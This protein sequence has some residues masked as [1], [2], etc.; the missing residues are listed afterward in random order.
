MRAEVELPELGD[1][2]VLIEVAFAG[3]NRHDCN[4]RRRG[5]SPLHSDTPG[6]EV[7]GIISGLGRRV[8]QFRIGDPV[9]ALVDGGG[10]ATHTTASAALVFPVL[11]ALDLKSASA[12]PE[13]LFTIWHNFVG[14]SAIGQG[15]SVLIHGGT[16]GVGS[17]A[18]QL[19]SRLGHTVFATCSSTEKMEHAS[20]L[21]A[22]AAFNYTN[23][24]FASEVLSAT[25]GQGVDV[26]L[27][28]AA[29]AHSSANLRALAWRG[30]IVHL[31]P[32][33]D[34]I[35]KAPLRTILEKEAK[36]TGSLLRPLSLSI[37]SQVADAL[38]KYVL[39][40]VYQGDVLPW[41]NEVYPLSMAAQAHRELESGSS[42]GKIVLEC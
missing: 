27:D 2:E 41:V 15:E 10:Y 36:I 3:V 8:H 19:L 4:Q 12:L 29:G 11:G 21:G 13:A 37:K 33:D 9:C 31:S 32:G 25:R 26:I 35:F 16:S 39:P 23:Q 14:V 40:L 7:S 24:D 38:R 6:L 1:E 30:R 18:I 28:V 5:P 20:R 17:L 42:M 34:A 22:R